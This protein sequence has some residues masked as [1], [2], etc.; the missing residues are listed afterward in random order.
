MIVSKEWIYFEKEKKRKKERVR[1]L[2]FDRHECVRTRREERNERRP[3]T[4][5]H[6]LP[7]METSQKRVARLIMNAIASSKQRTDRRGNE[8]RFPLTC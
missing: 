4:F 3:K 6:R 8:S 7:S 2:T 5:L 1:L